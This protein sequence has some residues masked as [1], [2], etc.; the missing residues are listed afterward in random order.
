ML[1][2]LFSFIAANSS[3]LMPIVGAVIGIAGGLMLFAKAAEAVKL[4]IGP[5][6]S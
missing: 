6:Y 1:T 4:A 5:E 2:G 3:W